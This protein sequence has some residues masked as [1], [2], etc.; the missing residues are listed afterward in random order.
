MEATL[1]GYLPRPR[2]LV[3][4]TNT[5][6]DPDGVVAMLNAGFAWIAEGEV[7]MLNDD[8]HGITTV[9]HVISEEH[10]AAEAWRVDRPHEHEKAVT[11]EE[12]ARERAQFLIDEGVA[13]INEG[14]LDLATMLLA[15][16]G[17]VLLKSTI[18]M[19]EP[20]AIAF[21]MSSAVLLE[22]LGRKGEAMPLCVD[23]AA[24]AERI[25]DDQ[26]PNKA[27]CFINLG[28]L[29]L[30]RGHRRKALANLTRGVTL[31]EGLKGDPDHIAQLL[32]YARTLLEQAR[33]PRRRAVPLRA[34]VRTGAE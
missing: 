5:G 32:A 7:V 3:I 24:L 22:K 13:C 19:T 21:Y 31:L 30:D 9:A 11:P 16:A 4:D 23:A 8:K 27:A 26:D 25:L 10:P 1:I 33:T 15:N 20:S 2:L 29:Q 34:V 18:G 12:Q 28:E 6:F 17:V 14:Q